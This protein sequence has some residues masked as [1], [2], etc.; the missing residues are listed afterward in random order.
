MGALERLK[1]IQAR[2]KKT[3]FGIGPE[4]TGRPGTST[5]CNTKRIFSLPKEY[6][7]DL[8]RSHQIQQILLLVKG[9]EEDI[10]ISIPVS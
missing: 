5:L 1:C 2:F 8:K 9:I 7:D 4:F 10:P 3:W 6:Q